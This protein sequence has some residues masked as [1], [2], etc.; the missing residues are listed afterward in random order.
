MLLENKETQPVTDT[1]KEVPKFQSEH[2]EQVFWAADSTEYIDRFQAKRQKFS[3]L[4]RSRSKPN[5]PKA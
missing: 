5:H 2:D 3:T 4:K 1:K